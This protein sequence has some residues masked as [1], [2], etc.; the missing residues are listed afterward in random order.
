MKGISLIKSSILLDDPE[1]GGFL[2][3]REFQ[4]TFY[5]QTVAVYYLLHF[6]G[7]AVVLFLFI[8]FFI[9]FIGNNVR[10]RSGGGF[11]STS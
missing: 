4:P 6:Q 9:S 10:F 2:S 3:S 7:G 11:M 8:L 5:S 1:L